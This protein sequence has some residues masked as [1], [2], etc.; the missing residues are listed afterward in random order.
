MVNFYTESNLDQ[1]RTKASKTTPDKKN[2]NLNVAGA[3]MSGCAQF[4]TRPAASLACLQVSLL[5]CRN[6]RV[7]ICLG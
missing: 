5:Q 1:T 2:G 4:C 6:E 7:F 3:C